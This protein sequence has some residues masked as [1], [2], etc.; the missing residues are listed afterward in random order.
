MIGKPGWSLRQASKE[1]WDMCPSASRRF[2]RQPPPCVVRRSQPGKLS[3]RP[4][5]TS[6]GNRASRND[7]RSWQRSWPPDTRPKLPRLPRDDRAHRLRGHQPNHGIPGRGIPPPMPSPAGR[8]CSRRRLPNGGA[9]L[10]GRAKRPR[11]F[12]FDKTAHSLAW[13]E[14][15]LL[16]KRSPGFA[17]GQLPLFRVQCSV[18]SGRWFVVRVSYFVFRI[19]YFVFRISYFVFRIS[20][21]V[22]RISY[23]VFR[24]SCSVACF[25]AP[26]PID[27]RRESGW[28]NGRVAAEGLG[29]GAHRAGR[30]AAALFIAAGRIGGAGG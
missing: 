14:Y 29:W 24:I 3:H 15:R 5:R 19:S 17:F 20:Y 22:F 16:R 25:G 4:A 9:W 6:R 11:P 12:R 28:F 10:A 13:R 7:W 2:T 8:G 30:G 26:E 21:F 23:F 1:R 27:F 18:I